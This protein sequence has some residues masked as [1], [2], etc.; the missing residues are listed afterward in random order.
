MV[1]PGRCV[2]RNNRK[3]WDTLSQAKARILDF[4]WAPHVNNGLKIA[5]VKFMQRVMLVQTRGN[6]D[7]RVRLLCL[8]LA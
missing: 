6:N 4:V 7:P 3:P 1:L 5:S 8:T 2:N